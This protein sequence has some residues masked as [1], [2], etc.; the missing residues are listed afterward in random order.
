[1]TRVRVSREPLDCWEALRQSH[2]RQSFYCCVLQRH[3]LA[4]QRGKP[5]LSSGAVLWYN[6]DSELSLC[7]KRVQTKSSYFGF[8]H[9][10]C[11]VIILPALNSLAYFK[12]LT[13]LNL[14]IQLSADIFGS[15]YAPA[16]QPICHFYF[17]N[18]RVA[19]FKSPPTQLTLTP[20]STQ[21]H[22][23]FPC[24]VYVTLPILI[25]ITRPSPVS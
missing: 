12:L 16:G 11:K 5:L 10:F 2:L 17:W 9:F 6:S 18:P 19:L 1:M 21:L 7:L 13:S 23:L 15:F 3:S 14:Q 24:K 8:G 20:T 4:V 22:A 25:S